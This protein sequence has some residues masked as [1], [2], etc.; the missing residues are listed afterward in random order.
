[1]V[2]KHYFKFVCSVISIFA[3]SLPNLVLL[4]VITFPALEKARS[5]GTLVAGIGRN[6]EPYRALSSLSFELGPSPSL[7]PS[8]N[9]ELR[10]LPSPGKTARAGPGP[11]AGP[12]PFLPY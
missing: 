3:R 4:L 6:F 8:M 12:S 5:D 11:R 1:M 9:F 2:H 7:G 10:A